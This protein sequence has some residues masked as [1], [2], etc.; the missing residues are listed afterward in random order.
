MK[1]ITDI[2]N[3]KEIPYTFAQ[4]TT[5]SF[6][7]KQTK[8]ILQKVAKHIAEFILIDM[9]PNS[10]S[11]VNKNRRTSR[12]V[13]YDLNKL[14]VEKNLFVVIFYANKRENLTEEFTKHFFETDWGIAM[15]MM[16]SNNILCYASQELT[17]GNWFNIV[18]F[19]KESDKHE[20]VTNDKHK[21][22]AYT[23]APKRFSWI[24][25]HNA[26]LPSG[27]T[28]FTDIIMK[29]TKYYYFDENWF[30]ERNY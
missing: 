11:F 3:Q 4:K 7:K 20:V 2:T 21:Y 5:T 27:I 14:L 13:I 9:R 18:L 29:K 23:V 30:A 22:A 8:K 12:I 1:S 16:G 28:N 10:V 25:L 26:F 6:D 17:D 15:N 24:R 19:T